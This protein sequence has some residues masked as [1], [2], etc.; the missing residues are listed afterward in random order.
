VW[1]HDHRARRWLVGSLSRYFARFYTVL[2]CLRHHQLPPRLFVDET[3][4]I[5]GRADTYDCPSGHGGDA[6]AFVYHKEDFL[7]FTDFAG[8]E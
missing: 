4:P 3:V 8:G 7:R 5:H 1:R 2:T 6:G